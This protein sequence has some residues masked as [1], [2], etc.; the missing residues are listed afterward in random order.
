MLKDCNLVPV[1]TCEIC[2]KNDWCME[3]ISEEGITEAFLCHRIPSDKPAKSGNGYLH[4]TNDVPDHKTPPRTTKQPTQSKA[5]PRMI[6]KVLDDLWNMTTLNDEHRAQLQARGL[7]DL[8]AYRSYPDYNETKQIMIRLLQRYTEAEILTVAGFYRTKNGTIWMRSA[9]DA[10]LIPCKDGERRTVGAQI[11]HNDSTNGPK[12]TWLSVNRQ[13]RRFGGSK[14]GLRSHVAHHPQPQITEK[15]F[16]EEL[17][18]TE[19][20]LKADITSE[21]IGM[22]CLGLAGVSAYDRSELKKT[23]RKLLAP[24]LQL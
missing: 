18:I 10:T 20:I 19:G 6:S 17:Y 13:K 12:Y 24:K 11:R 15:E 1:E 3:F 9:K 7:N 2:T 14:A 23:L 4:F 21:K 5:C 8:S 16:S 22:V